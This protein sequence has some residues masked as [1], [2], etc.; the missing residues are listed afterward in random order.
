MAE[1]KYFQYGTVCRK[2]MEYK[3][4][5]K[6]RLLSKRKRENIK[7]INKEQEKY[8][9][10]LR[11]E[12]SERNKYPENKNRD[13]DNKY[14]FMGAEKLEKVKIEKFEKIF[15]WIG[16]SGTISHI[17]KIKKKFS[18]FGTMHRRC[19]VYQKR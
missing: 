4:I 8:Y 14:S 19:T 11:T 15:V 13:N 12:I 5:I 7:K 1:T 2:N 10:E 18:I 17:T 9:K 16:D 3:R 6:N